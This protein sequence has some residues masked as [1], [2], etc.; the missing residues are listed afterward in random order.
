MLSLLILMRFDYT[1]ST[2]PC[3]KNFHM[4]YKEKIFF[5]Q[6]IYLAPLLFSKF[7][8][9][10][11][12]IC[13]YVCKQSLSLPPISILHD[14]YFMSKM[15]ATDRRQSYLTIFP[16]LLLKYGTLKMIL[17]FDLP[18]NNNKDSLNYLYIA[19][20]LKLLFCVFFNIL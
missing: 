10:C 18:L 6:V 7:V 19:S 8:Y 4:I 13:K 1:Y 16:L 20:V 3:Y 9:G 15:A 5:F 11:L 14:Q 12:I 2:V 17:N